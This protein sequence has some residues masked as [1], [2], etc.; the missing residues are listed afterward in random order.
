MTLLYNDLH[1]RGEET[2]DLKVKR[3]QIR[4]DSLFELYKAEFN[5]SLPEL[6]NEIGIHDEE[7]FVKAVK[8][9]VDVGRDGSETVLVANEVTLCDLN[10]KW[11]NWIHRPYNPK[12]VITFYQTNLD[13]IDKLVC[14]NKVDN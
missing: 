1:S 8:D 4:I 3:A 5:E 6:W 12:E 13:F 7:D 11:M 14:S 10:V 9:L 2:G